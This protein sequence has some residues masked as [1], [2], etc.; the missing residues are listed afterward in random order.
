M[1]T[2]TFT[3]KMDGKSVVHVVVRGSAKTMTRNIVDAENH[4]IDAGYRIAWN[5]R[6]NTKTQREGI[7]RPKK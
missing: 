7:A 5:E 2:F 6:A 1:A 4:A 3:G